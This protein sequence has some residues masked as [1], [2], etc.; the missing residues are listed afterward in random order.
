MS[1]IQNEVKTINSIQEYKFQNL[2]SLTKALLVLLYIAIVFSVLSILDSIMSYNLYASA[3]YVDISEEEILNNDM[4]TGVIAII[5]MLFYI[6]TIVIF[7][8]WVNKANKN[9]RALG[10]KNMRF[11]PGWCVGWWFIPIALWWKPYQAVR[12]IWKTSQDAGNWESQENSIVSLWWT[13]WIISAI[14]NQII[15]RWS[16][17]LYSNYNSTLLDYQ[18][19][20]LTWI[21]AGIFDIVLSLVFIKMIREI[22]NKQLTQFQ[23]QSQN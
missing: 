6:A 13:L 9:S 15:Q 10:A 7:L 22:C 17:S 19:V 8:I 20:E 11:T 21:F 12:E 23:N 16:M 4:R 3:Q 18:N 5:G 14:V 2:S 1:Q